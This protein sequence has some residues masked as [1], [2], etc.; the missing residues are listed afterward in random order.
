METSNKAGEVKMIETLVI[1]HLTGDL[2]M[3]CRQGHYNVASAF[4][5]LIACPTCGRHFAVRPHII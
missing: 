4:S 2:V 5:S 1:D 3:V